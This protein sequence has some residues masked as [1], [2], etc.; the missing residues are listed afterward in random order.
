MQLAEYGEKYVGRRDLEDGERI[1]A[2]FFLNRAFDGRFAVGLAWG[3]FPVALAI[4]GI[5]FALK[6]SKRFRVH[7]RQNSAEASQATPELQKIIRLGA[8]SMC[9]SA[10]IATVFIAIEIAIL[11]AVAKVTGT[12]RYLRLRD[13]WGRAHR[14]VS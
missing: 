8:I 2:E 14:V 3:V 1:T 7:V 11:V 5:I 10:P 6:G 4:I 12:A 13:L 9:G